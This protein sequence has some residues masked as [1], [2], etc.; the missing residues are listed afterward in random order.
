[1]LEIFL[2]LCYNLLKHTENYVDDCSI[3]IKLLFKI[4]SELDD[5]SL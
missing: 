1:M 2:I 5:V 4:Y 3:V